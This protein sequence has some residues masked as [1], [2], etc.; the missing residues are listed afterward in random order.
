MYCKCIQLNSMKLETSNT[1]S[2][3][4]QIT[5]E[6][7]LQIIRGNVLPDEKLP[8]FD[9]LVTHFNTSRSIVQMAVS[10]LREMGFIRSDGRRGMFV[11]KH[12][13]HLYRYGILF[14]GHPGDAYWSRFNT[15]LTHEATRLQTQTP[16]YQF[17]C[18]YGLG[19][20]N[21]LK[22]FN[23]LLEDVQNKT[24]AGLMVMPFCDHVFEHPVMQQKKR[25]DITSIWIRRLRA[26]PL[27][28]DRP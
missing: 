13:P 1:K 18:Y 4:Q 26:S 6:L 3:Y 24:L 5:D 28:I 25:S 15:S 2:R 10:Q 11:Q 9:T 20:K 19:K 12:P 8:T 17:Q 22:D 23:Q 21:T 14:P 16:G 7:R 27:S